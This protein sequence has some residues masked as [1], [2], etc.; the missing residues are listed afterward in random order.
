[1]MI[2]RFD[3]KLLLYI[4]FNQYLKQFIYSLGSDILGRLLTPEEGCG[5][6]PVDKLFLMQYH[7]TFQLN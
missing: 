5:I 6:Q 3:W 1:M 2:S 7:G 4:D